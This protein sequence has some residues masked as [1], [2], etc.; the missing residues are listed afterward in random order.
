MKSVPGSPRREDGLY[1]QGAH[2]SQ[3]LTKPDAALKP[4]DVVIARQLCTTY[5]RST[6][7]TSRS[8]RERFLLAPARHMPPAGGVSSLAKS[9]RWSIPTGQN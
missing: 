9:P 1:E 6:A 8:D 3:F 2:S 5:L 4:R 7:S